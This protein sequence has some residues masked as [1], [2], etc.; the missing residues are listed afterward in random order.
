M[1]H[2][3]YYIGTCSIIRNPTCVLHLYSGQ[4]KQSEIKNKTIVRLHE[5][6][7]TQFIIL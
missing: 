1:Y 4:Y 3:L 5:Y 6:Y 7:Y 2:K